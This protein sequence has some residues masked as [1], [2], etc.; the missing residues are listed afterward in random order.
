MTLQ[1]AD[2]QEPAVYAL[3]LQELAVRNITAA[4]VRMAEL[5]SPEIADEWRDGLL[6]DIAGLATYPR[7]HPLVAEK[8]KREVRHFVYSRPKSQTAYRVLFTITGEQQSSF[9]PPTVT[10]LHVRHGATRP[11][12]RVEARQIEMLE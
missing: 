12:T 3:R 1:N 4:Y 6:R 8:F 7:R 9:D 11:I 5:V 10:I 2:N